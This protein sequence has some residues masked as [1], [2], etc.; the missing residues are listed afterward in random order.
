MIKEK[1]VA[2]EKLQ[3]NVTARIKEVDSLLKSTNQ[4]VEDNISRIASLFET[5]SAQ[6]AAQLLLELDL[7]TAVR[8]YYRMNN[9]R[10]AEVLNELMNTGNTKKTKELILEFQRLSE[11]KKNE[12]KSTN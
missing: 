6:T 2:F 10:S 11:E 9:K 7:P 8:I 12:N 1:Q 4:K 3:K 5:A